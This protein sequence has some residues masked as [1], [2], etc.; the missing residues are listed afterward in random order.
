MRD[1]TKTFDF[2]YASQNAE[3]VLPPSRK[4]ET[5]GSTLINYH[6]VSELLDEPGRVDWL[7]HSLSRPETGPDGA[8]TLRRGHIRLAIR[9]ETGLP[10][11]P[12][13][14][15]RFETE[16]N[17]GEPEAYRVDMP[18]QYHMRFTAPAARVH[19]IRVRFTVT[20]EGE[21]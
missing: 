16:V 5:F 17:E 9:P 10:D 6:L 20:R 18:P 12:E 2:W 4:L 13:V 7:L 15:D 1:E 3:I 14:T 19:E 21:A 11:P 8:L